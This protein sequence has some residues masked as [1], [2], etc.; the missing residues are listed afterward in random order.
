M[1]HEEKEICTMIVEFVETHWDKI[2]LKKVD[3]TKS[4]GEFLAEV[5]ENFQSAMWVLTEVAHWGM[6]K[7]YLQDIYEEVDPDLFF[8]VVKLNMNYIKLDFIDHTYVAEY[9]KP[10]YKK[11]LYFD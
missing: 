6:D 4:K 9:A 8:K 1:K 5:K 2:D 10:K 3:L 11:V 7:Q